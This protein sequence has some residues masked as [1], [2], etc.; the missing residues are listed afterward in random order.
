MAELLPEEM[1]VFDLGREIEIP[2]S[3]TEGQ[4]CFHLCIWFLTGSIPEFQELPTYNAHIRQYLD[5]L[6]RKGVLQWDN[7]PFEAV[8]REDLR[9]VDILLSLSVGVYLIHLFDRILNSG[10][11]VVL[12]NEIFDPGVNRT[13]I[14]VDK[15]VSL[16]Q[17]RFSVR[18]VF[19]ILS[20]ARSVKES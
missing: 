11:W 5:E 12:A 7:P 6:K 1:E 16:L 9:P 3:L 14:P 17:N 8:I 18:R 19:P 13:E 10:H 4:F 2:P 20:S 15:W